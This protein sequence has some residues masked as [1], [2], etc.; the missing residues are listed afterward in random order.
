MDP[1]DLVRDVM[2]AA[3]D[4]NGR[5]L[6]TRFTNR[7][8]FAI[9]VPDQGESML[10][11]V[12][13]D[14]GEEFGL[15]LFRGE[16]AAAC[17]AA[18]WDPAGAG[19]DVAEQTDMLGFSM[20]SFG[21]LPPE[22]QALV[23]EAGV[24]PKYNEPIPHF[25]VK[26]PGRQQ[27]MPDE[28]ELRLLLAV[29]RGA[30]EADRKRL[31]KPAR[32]EN[33][34]GVCTLHLSGDPAAPQVSVTRE[35]WLLPE[36]PLL[37]V[38]G[39][40]S[41]APP[42]S[43]EMA[44]L[45]GL[46]RLDATWLVGLPPSPTCVQGDDRSFQLLLAVDDASEFVLQGR[47]FPAGELGEAIDGLLETF[48]RGGLAGR[49]GLPREIVFSSQA[50]HDAMK[51]LLERVGV[52]CI[53]M[54][55]IPKLQEI[56]AEMQEFLGR[57]PP[58]FAEPLEAPGAAEDKVPA[59]DDL[60]GWKEVD[61]RIGGRFFKAANTVVWLSSSRAV[62]RYFGRDDLRDFFEAHQQRGVV[63]AYS[64]WAVLDYRTTRK[65]KTYAEEMLAEGLPEAEAMLVRAR[66]EAH[67]TLYRVASH[68]PKAGTVDLED[69]LLG[70]TATVHDQLMSE[71]IEDSLF[72]AARAFAA[73]RFHFIEPAGPPLGAGMGMEAVEFLQDCGV[74]FTR[75]GLRDGAHVFGWLWDWAD[76]W[77]ENFHP[78]LCNTDKED[79]LWHTVSFSVADLAAV[80][81]A[82]LQR[83]DLDHDEVNDEFVWL[84]KT[85]EGAKMLGGPVTL[86][87]IEFIGD[88]L[89]LTV[90]SSERFARARRWL[91]ALPG[92]VFHKVT[93]RGMDEAEEDR[94]MDERIAKPE[95]V[96]ITP[97]MASAL[98]EMF[99]KR[100]MEWLDTPLP[101]LG[102][103]TP[104]QT[105]KTAAGRQQI[106]MMIRTIPDPMGPSPIRVPRQAMLRELGLEHEAETEPVAA[107]PMLLP[108]EGI[109]PA[110]D[111]DWTD[112]LPIVNNSPKIGRNDPCPCG[113]GK[114][115]K[116][117]CGRQTL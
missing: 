39:E 34:E 3:A 114:K 101:V 5:R 35:R 20:D 46:P 75:D 67:P 72:L 38:A 92:V 24:H 56:N 90:N 17:L 49:K 14:V 50:L 33:E 12:M 99:E 58:P 82:L 63:M 91:E 48:R 25:V 36:S 57:E 93:T 23:R 89:V 43:A 76:E 71:N 100:Y 42:L 68:D 107:P 59:P 52:K 40:S 28:S 117:C 86:G 70:G 22:A 41:P 69:I 55:T 87:R 109:E 51:P 94:P 112:G 77:Q 102:G 62:K 7:H 1:Q 84:K 106:T 64:T 108:L 15:S 32:L 105:C 13:G 44:N 18:L 54:P 97:G 60:A 80:R 19:D 85:G 81:Q 27:R 47:I 30:V 61:R 113:S 73:G 104:R 31:L 9:G 2:Q 111:D 53:Y 110:E 8:C 79:L 116:K 26:R 98:Q 115:Y 103:R 11:V 88:E 74:E 4:F 45:S 66:I 96:E 10:G 95:P 78:H 21:D 83:K 37:P 6:W 16:K 29:L 65:S